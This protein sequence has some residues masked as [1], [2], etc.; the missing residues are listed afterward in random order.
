MLR[1]GGA[2]GGHGDG[3]DAVGA[4]HG[5]LALAQVGDDDLVDVKVVEAHG[6]R[7]DVHDGVDGADLMEMHLVGRR[8]MSRRL[9]LGEHLED[10]LC[11][12]MGTR[13][14]RPGVDDG[15]DFGQAAMLMVM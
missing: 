5:A 14:Q 7:D 12:P 9:G 10:A 6:R 13:G 3:Q 4:A 11:N 8:P 1:D 2:D 15:H